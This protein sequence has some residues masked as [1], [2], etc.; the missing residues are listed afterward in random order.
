MSER[1]DGAATFRVSGSAYD[2]LVGRYSPALAAAMADAARI[3]PGKRALDVGCGPGALTAELASRLGAEHV[4]AVDPSAPFLEECRSRNPGVDVREGRAETLPFEDAS[5]D[6][7]LAQLVL[8]FVGDP[9]AAA[10]EMRRVLRPGGIAAAC[11]W[12]FGE[13]M[14]VLRAF[15]DAALAIDPTAPDERSTMRFGRDGE[16]AWLFV[17]SG[18]RDVTSGALHVAAD[19]DD[20][21]DLWAGFASGVGPSGA[22]C[23]ALDEER[24]ER[25]REDLRARL[26]DP[27]GP[28]ALEAVAWYATGRRR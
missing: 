10:A 15:W 17:E 20:F 22:F 26:G 19:Y 5:F 6:A 12:D 7:V 18:L 3:R 16:I 13:G 14:R 28:F 1:A 2:R 4:S 8:H 25:L 21:D 11:V 23:T 9:A 27:T 24:R